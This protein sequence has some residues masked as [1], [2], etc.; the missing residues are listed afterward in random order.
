[1]KKITLPVS[2]IICGSIL[3]G[4]CQSKSNSS[5]TEN[6][7]TSNSATSA[8]KPI[9]I[10]LDSDIGQD[11]DDAAAM[12]IMH[13]F[14]DKGEVEILATMFPMQD[15][16][17]APAMDVIN[18]YYGRPD[19]PIGTYK[20]NFKYRGELWDHYNTK[21]ANKFP[22]DLKT[23]KD[24]PDAIALYRQILAKQE[25]TS[26]V[27]VAVGPER[28]L[29]D[30]LKSGPDDYSQLS[31]RDLVKQKVKMLSV[32][33]A[34]FPKGDEW[35]IKIAPDAS[36]LVAETWPTPIV[37]SGNEIG[38]AIRT[39]RRLLTEAPENSP[40]RASFENHPFVDSVTKDRQSWDQTAMLFAVQGTQNNWKLESNGFNNIDETGKN[41]W[42]QNTD[43]DH[44]YLIL[45]R[46]A[47]EVAKVIED[48]M[49]APPA[50]T[51][52]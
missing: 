21:L 45:N 33:G 11:C 40:V 19:I 41:E 30:L 47:A 48:L 7:A 24:A 17:G 14:A 8:T 35:N 25:D 1:M 27:I 18:T 37:Y 20:G 51:K 2:L 3:L 38:Q 12:A 6:N 15:P 5:A 49:V 10:I 23:G 4:S 52:K 29:A 34:G 36:K 9:K 31:G 50:S 44:S 26:V 46:P 28:L 43:K 22:H 32:M 13:Q 39:G 16:M 42:R